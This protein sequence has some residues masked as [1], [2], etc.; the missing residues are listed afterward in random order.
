MP[1]KRQPDQTR[2]DLLEAAFHE[3]HKNGFRGAS[4]DTILK[5][6]GVTKGALYHHFRSKAELGYVVIEEIVKPFVE[7]NW[8]PVLEADNVIDGSIDVLHRRVAERSEMALSLGCPFNNL[9][10]EMSPVEEG[11]RLRL[12]AILQTWREGIVA[13]LTRGQ[14]RGHVRSDIDVQAVSAFL[15]SAIEGCVGMAKGAQSR[16]FYSLGMDGLEAYLNDL[17]APANRAGRAA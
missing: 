17:R 7:Q 15:I 5:E 16:E 11:F 12:N 3:I 1:A 8:L 13:G 9:V 2:Q 10:Q 4:L 14:E 6:T